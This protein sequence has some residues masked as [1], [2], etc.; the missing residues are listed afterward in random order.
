MLIMHSS[1]KYNYSASH[2]AVNKVPG[3]KLVMYDGVLTRF[4]NILKQ[5]TST[6]TYMRFL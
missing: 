6:L 5:G 4:E 1:C 2:L 3:Y